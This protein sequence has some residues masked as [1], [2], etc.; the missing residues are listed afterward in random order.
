[1]MKRF[2]WIT[3]W[4]ERTVSEENTRLLTSILG[5][6]KIKSVTIVSWLS[7]PTKDRV[8]VAIAVSW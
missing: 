5:A 7:S 3:A 8:F 6:F 4:S 1:M 2:L